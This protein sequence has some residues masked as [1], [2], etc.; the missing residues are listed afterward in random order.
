ML[1][2]LT[3]PVDKPAIVSLLLLER[4]L[5]KLVMYYSCLQKKLKHSLE[6]DVFVKDFP[7]KSLVKSLLL[8]KPCFEIHVICLRPPL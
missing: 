3:Q 7:N 8:S 5:T 6:S 1:K 2:S 4:E